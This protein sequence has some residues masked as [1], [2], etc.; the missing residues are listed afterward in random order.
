MAVNGESGAY[1]NDGYVLLARLYPKELVSAFHARV[2]PDRV[3]VANLI[4]RTE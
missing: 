2:Q 3:T 4:A 1:A